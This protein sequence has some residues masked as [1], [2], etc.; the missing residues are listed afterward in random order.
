MIHEKSLGLSLQGMEDYTK[1]TAEAFYRWEFAKNKKVS[2]RLFAG[3]FLNNK[4][5][6]N[7][8]L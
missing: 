6:N 8:Y 2:F 5:R 3:M 4:T 1:A 7:F